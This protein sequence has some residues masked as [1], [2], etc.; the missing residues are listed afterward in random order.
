MEILQPLTADPVLGGVALRRLAEAHERRSFS[1]LRFGRYA[2]SAVGYTAALAAA[3]ASDQRLPSPR[4]PGL[5][6]ASILPW[7]G[8]ALASSNRVEEAI[9]ANTEG[10]DRLREFL[11]REPYL[12]SARRQLAYASSN[13]AR[14][15]EA[16]WD[17]AAADAA[18]R[19]AQ[20]CYDQ[21]LKLDPDNTSALNNLSAVYSGRA[22]SAAERRDFAAA[23]KYLAECLVILDRPNASNFMKYNQLY[24]AGR[25]ARL[26]VRQG[27]EADAARSLAQ[28]RSLTAEVNASLPAESYD[29]AA[30][31]AQARTLVADVDYERGNLTAVRAQM[32]ANVQALAPFAA[33]N[34]QAR[35]ALAGAHLAA[36]QAAWEQ[37]DTAAA[38]KAFASFLSFRRPPS[39]KPLLTERHYHL[40]LQLW[41]VRILAAAGRRDE[42]R[43]LITKLK[44]EIAAVCGAAPDEAFTKFTRGSALGIEAQI[45]DTLTPAARRALLNQS[46]ALL[47]PLAAAGQLTPSERRT[48]LAR[49]EAALVQLDGKP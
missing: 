29:R 10:R 2:D 40:G 27:N 45:D 46:L 42:A 4:R 12:V 8:E 3:N 21:I 39:D 28:V 15:A 11:A 49:V 17:F 41:H 14:I 33:G 47:R 6:A 48:D 34:E 32:A 26:T 44:P 13:A 30:S 38:E 36:A 24:G 9:A 43:A 25:L 20:D 19:E 31:D 35:E 5:R 18:G 7:V 16:H 1:L 23:E 22:A 37:C